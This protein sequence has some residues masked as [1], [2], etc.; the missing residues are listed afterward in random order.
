MTARGGTGV[1]FED[2]EAKPGEC[3]PLAEGAVLLHGYALNDATALMSA[4]DAVVAAAPWRNMT[5]PGGHRM[6]V[7]MTNCGAFGWVSDRR[8]Y[9]YDEVDP[10]S[11]QPWPAMPKAFADI[12][13]HAATAA[14]YN[15]FIPDACLI[16]QYEPGTRLTLHQDK[17]ERDF[18]API[19]SVS[20]GLPATFLFGGDE[21]A[22]R[23]KRV[24]LFHGD[25]VVWGGKSRLAFHG[26]L[27]LKEGNHPV[28]GRRRINLTLRKAR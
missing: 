9:R 16:N 20:L 12:A 22:D 13:A 3:Q 18:K 1:L 2:L 24:R 8:G 5:T 15:A 25:V 19:V 4:I 27:P 17:N 28:T 7:A 26:I 23:T 21:R 14:G 11:S 10:D 6:S